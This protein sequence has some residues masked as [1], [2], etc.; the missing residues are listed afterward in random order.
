LED[1]GLDIIADPKLLEDEVNRVF[2]EQYLANLMESP[3]VVCLES[4][5]FV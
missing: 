2:K 4:E 3:P 5:R 1:Q